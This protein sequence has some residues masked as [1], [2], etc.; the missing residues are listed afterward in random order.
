ML[1]MPS[2]TL[3]S[4]PRGLRWRKRS[5]PVAGRR[6]RRAN[7]L[8][9]AFGRHLDLQQRE[10]PFGAGGDDP[11][12]LKLRLDEFAA[13]AALK[14]RHGDLVF[15]GHD[16]VIGHD[17]AGGVDDETAAQPHRCGHRHHGLA[18]DV[19]QFLEG[20]KRSRSVRPEQ[21]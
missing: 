12:V 2:E 1:T 9:A 18:H 15:A 5:A 7:G 10:V 11:H 14:E 19:R 17:I 16:V 20:Q 21:V 8:E 13:F 4:S 6:S 3:R